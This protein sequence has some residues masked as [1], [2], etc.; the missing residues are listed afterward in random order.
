MSTPFTLD[1]DKILLL[2][3]L[4]RRIVDKYEYVLLA[5]KLGNGRTPNEVKLRFDELHRQA[6]TRLMALGLAVPD[7]GYAGEDFSEYEVK[8]CGGEGRGPETR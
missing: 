5:R 6:A 7:W 3:C 2:T 8:E 4:R 1:E